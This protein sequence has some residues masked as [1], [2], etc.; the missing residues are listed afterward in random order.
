MRMDP[1]PRDPDPEPVGPTGPIPA[2]VCLDCG[3]E[4][5]PSEECTDCGSTNLPE[6]E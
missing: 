3:T 1:K 5:L 4:Q 2:T 6:V